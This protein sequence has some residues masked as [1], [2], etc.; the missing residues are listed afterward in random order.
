MSHTWPTK[1]INKVSEINTNNLRLA[2]NWLEDN[3]NYS[4][5]KIDK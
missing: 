4:I 1:L 5:E 3:E 2:Q